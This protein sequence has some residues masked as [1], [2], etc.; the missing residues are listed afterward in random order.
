MSNV[1]VCF[2]LSYSFRI[3]SII[4][5]PSQTT[6]PIHFSRECLRYVYDMIKDNGTRCRRQERFCCCFFFISKERKEM[7][8]FARCKNPFRVPVFHDK[9]SK[10]TRVCLRFVSRKVTAARRQEFRCQ[11]AKRRDIIFYSTE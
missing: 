6:I 5:F 7:G 9:R 2:V 3:R 8:T 10:S 1:P 4:L 11:R